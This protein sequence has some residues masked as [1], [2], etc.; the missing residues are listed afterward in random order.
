MII[1][2][3]Y[4]QF[5]DNHNIAA[6]FIKIARLL[7][8]KGESSFKVT[9]Y[10]RA[11]ESIRNTPENL[12]EMDIP[13][14]KSI[15]GVGQAIAEKIKEL[16]QTGNLAFLDRLEGEIP[17]ALL[18]W[19]EL[20]GMGPKTTALIWK[21]LGITTIPELHTAAQGGKLHTIPG[22]RKKLEAKILAAIENR[23][24]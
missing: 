22:I 4:N 17:P 19:L 2:F 11:A 23:H 13:A 6:V 12:T 7:K 16:N 14:L 1:L 5:M 3:R 9:A 18:D 21:T 24:S 10:E 15:P 20:P 8:I